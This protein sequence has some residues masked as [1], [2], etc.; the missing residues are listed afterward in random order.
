M[1]DLSGQVVKGYELRELIG[2]GGFAAVYRA[3]QFVV[4]REVAIKVILSKHAN[5]PDFIRRFEAEAQL[6]A[7]LEHIH[8]VPLYDYW[9]QPNNA[10]LVMRWLRGG[11]LFDLLQEQRIWGLNEIARLL[12]QIA[13]ALMVAHRNGVVHQDL[14]P[15]NILF[16]EDKNAYLTD[17]G[18]AKRL[19]Q[20]IEQPGKKPVFGTPTYMSPEQIKRQ[21]V[22]AQTDIYSLGII[23]YQLLTGTLPFDAPKVTEVLQKQVNDPLPPL[24]TIRPDLPYMLDVVL[25]QATSKNPA[26]RYMDAK[27]LA[28]AFRHAIQREEE[29]ASSARIRTAGPIA[30]SSPE[31]TRPLETPEAASEDGFQTLDFAAL[32]E[33]QNPYKGLRAF[34]EADATHFFGRE[35]LIRHLLAKLSSPAGRFLAI[36]GPSG[37]GK[38]SVVKAGLI[39]LLRGGVGIESEHWFVARMVPGAHPLQELETALL[40]IAVGNYE[41]L[42][43]QLRQSD[44]GLLQVVPQILPDDAAELVLIIDQFEEVFTL[45]EDETERNHF[46]DS[47]VTAVKT[48]SSRLRVVVTLRADFYDRPLLYPGFGELVQAYTEVVLPLAS[49]ELRQVIVGPAERA[50]VA[51]ESGLVAA[52]VADVTEQP[53]ALPLLQYALTEL[54]ERREDRLLTLDAYRSS[55]G[56]RG[57]LARRAE[58][59]YQSMEPAHQDAA[60]QLFLR[61]V[62][63]DEGSEDTRRRAR[64]AELM[65]V[66]RARKQAM[67]AV[68]DAYGKYRLI[69]FDHDPQT[70]EPTV[71]VAHE[72]LIREWARLRGWLDENRDELRTQRRLASATA[73]WIKANRDG[74]FLATGTRLAQFETLVTHTRLG[75]TDDETAYVH[76]SIALRKRAARRVQ[77]FITALVIFSLVALTLAV[78]AFDRQQRADN[79]RATSVAERD[80]AD[81]QAKI[82][83]SRELAVTALRNIEQLDQALLLSLEALNAADTFEAR[84]SL[85]MALLSN[86]HLTAFLSGHHDAVRSVA[87]SPDGRLIASGS[88]DGAI[89]VWDAAT[90]RALGQPLTGHTDRVNSVA[91][92][93]DG[94]LLASGGADNT[95]RLWDVA[96]GA[97]RGQ[98]LTGHEDAVWSVA[99]SPDG[100]TLASGSSDGTVMLWDVETGERLMPPLTG[101]QDEV[102][103][104]AFSPDGQR[105]AS[106]GADMMIILWDV[107]TGEPAGESLSGHEDWIYSLAFSP[108]GRL[109]ASGGADNTIRLWDVE[110][111]DP[112]GLPLQ[113]HT[114]WV[115]HVTFSPDGA[116]LISASSDD[117]VRLW[118]VA[119]GTA[120][121]TLAGH[122]G[123]V[124]SVAVGPDGYTLVSGDADGRVVL[125]N[126]S[127]RYPLRRLLSGHYS[128][129]ASVAFSPDG[130]IL[131]SSS[132]APAGGGDDLSVR[133]WDV[134]TGDP[135]AILTGHEGL[136]SSVAFSPDGRML[137]SASADRTL[138]LWNVESGESIGQPL[139]G[140]TGAVF[141]ASFS[142]DGQMIA[143]AGDDG[144]VILWNVSTGQ[145]A[146]EPLT[147][148]EDGVLSV[149]F[150]PDGRLLASGDRAGIIV[151]WDVTTHQPLG[152]SLNGHTDA[153]T[154]LAFS[155]DG[156]LLASGS[157]DATVIL[158]DTTT[159]QPIHPPLAGHTNYVTGVTFS[160]D[161]QMLA[162]GSWD[163]TV[164]L[165]D[166]ATG[167]PLG[168]PLMGHQN[169]VSSVAFSPDGRL[170]ASGSWDFTVGLWDVSPASW[171]TRACSVANRN[172]T[173]EEWEQYFP[174]M[175]YRETC[176]VLW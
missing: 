142:P 83:R 116:Q 126:T 6:I 129:V 14:T 23:L 78:F 151:V 9:R 48:P 55:G 54:F 134:S 1:N 97:P 163:S 38:S 12:D 22:T 91:F 96:T 108:D 109:L 10:Y 40:S 167:R 18:I 59:L 62:S 171:Q 144:T 149:V 95:I 119:T 52:I 107:S 103:T 147:G 150:S 169:R 89:M 74:S 3:Y 44:A 49:E 76:A 85:L 138:R 46:L 24:Q 61:L 29:T 133:L 69:T 53:G 56:V 81:E 145:L 176:P 135:L 92:S 93:P 73:E 120:L 28:N 117:T 110:T 47:L 100:K 102:Y 101:H 71:E 148:H 90:R 158:W 174:N 113:G 105:L 160:P 82:S 16:D 21:P 161:G 63:L 26:M 7:R 159:W 65:S 143:S 19:S 172:L 152:A 87:F 43:D 68:M 32:L 123:E 13:A 118:D 17:F 156:R 98:P 166:V 139:A 140:H 34:E 141:A 33:P 45:V 37:S 88:R 121:L 153:V 58:E 39:P 25:L 30:A 125:W 51:L 77:L 111:G 84:N 64:W 11:S 57:A 36:I 42:L 5:A 173:S 27:S 94:R 86:P 115:R 155:P 41:M 130:R 4:E 8:I 137:V 67:Q 35:G 136:V 106:A 132:G 157:R 60:R 114:D 50:G 15:G 80:R 165:W 131:A 2:V 162:S 79:A 164:I 66:R 70:R 124:W 75:L 99:F 112:V 20:E 128:E 175:D 122:G 168:Q 170:L 72:A 31:T 104:V 127:D 154:T 146:A